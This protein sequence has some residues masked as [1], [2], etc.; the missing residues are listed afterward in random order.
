[1][2][3]L[4]KKVIIWGLVIVILAISINAI[5][6]GS[7]TPGELDSFATCLTS[8]GVAMYGT[9][10]CS[11]CQNQKEMFGKSFKKINFI[12]CDFKSAEC[13]ANGIQS[14]PTWRINGEN[15]VG[16]QQ[17]SRLSSLTGCPLN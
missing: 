7:S 6:K 1:M 13:Y 16:V 4:T 5:V 14:Y 12:D 17:L 10:W 9:S 8:K 15:Y 3:K 2:K 11:H